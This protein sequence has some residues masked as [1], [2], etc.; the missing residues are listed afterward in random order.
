VRALL[1]LAQQDPSMPVL[2]PTIAA[3]ERLPAPF[4]AKLLRTLSEAKI[5][6]S[7]RGP[8]GGYKLAKSPD[9]ITLNEVAILFEGLALA[10]ECLLGYGV[11]SDDTPCP[12]HKVWGPR[13]TYMQDFM[14]QTTIGALLRLESTREAA[15]LGAPRRGR[16]PKDGGQ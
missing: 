7:S 3:A 6:S 4:L 9:E 16:R 1:Y 11:C 12:V 13:K 10:H 14:C 2:A 5:L 15:E 8:G